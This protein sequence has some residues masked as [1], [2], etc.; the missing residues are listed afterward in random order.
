MS[1]ATT[2]KSPQSPSQPTSRARSDASKPRERMG[3]GPPG[4]T[5]TEKAVNFSSSLR[6]LLGHLRPERPVITFVIALAAAGVALNVIGPKILARATNLI[7]AGLLGKAVAAQTPQGAQLPTKDLVIAQLNASPSAANH[8]LAD[9]IATLD[10]VP[11]QGI[12]FHALAMVLTLAIA[13]YVTSALLLWL[14]GYLLNG[15]VQRSIYRMRREVQH[16]LDRLPLSYFDSQPRGELLSR[17]T[18]DIDNV[19]QSLQ[20]SLS[21]MLNAVLMVIG[22][23]TMMFSTSWFLALIALSM[24]PFILLNASLVMKQSQKRFAAVWETTGHMNASVEEGFS[25]HALVKV[26]GRQQEVQ[27]AFEEQNNA[28]KTASQSSQ[29]LSA[30]LMPITFFIG[31]VNYVVIAVIGG[32][33]VAHGQMTLGDVQAFIQYSRMF[34]QPLTQ[35]ASMMNVLQS[36][37][38]SAERVFDVL[39]A[40]EQSSEA[41]GTL[42]TPLEGRVVFDDVAFSYTDEPLIDGLDLTVEPGQTVAIVGPTGAGKTTLVNL[43]MRFYEVDSGR[44]TLDGVDITDVPRHVLRDQMGMVLQDTW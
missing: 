25:G 24:V 34:T 21:Q 38:A 41:Q 17:V 1:E 36:G 29:F 37:V 22:V 7:F 40:P 15:A 32:L 33:R 3:G 2:P 12:D 27:A 6:R 14:Q 35:I 16:K 11:G 42:T 13:C 19:T 20:Q 44:I 26:F 4:L 18:N 43:L 31:N 10:V 30:L 8:R 23:A 28:L 5:P 39:D 9:M